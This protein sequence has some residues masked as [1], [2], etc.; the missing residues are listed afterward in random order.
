MTNLL[1]LKDVCSF[2]GYKSEEAAEALLK[3]LAVPYYDLTLAGG[4]G[5]R[6]RKSD[7]EDALIKIEVQ[8]YKKKNKVRHSASNMFDLPV[9]EAMALLT[10][11]GK[12]Q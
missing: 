1:A 5:R 12:Q 9:A 7:I 10:A 11:N 8:P 3:R 6:W 4:R 2:F